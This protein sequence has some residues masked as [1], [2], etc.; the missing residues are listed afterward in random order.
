MKGKNELKSISLVGLL[1]AF[2]FAVMMLLAVL[3]L[4]PLVIL[5]IYAVFTV[6]NML[7]NVLLLKLGLVESTLLGNI[8]IVANTILSFILTI[9]A[10][11]YIVKLKYT[12]GSRKLIALNGCKEKVVKKEFDLAQ[13]PKRIMFEYSLKSPYKSLK[14]VLSGRPNDDVIE[15]IKS[16]YPEWE[17]NPSWQIGSGSFNFIKAINFMNRLDLK[18]LNEKVPL[19][20]E[21]IRLLIINLDN[22]EKYSV[23]LEPTRGLYYIRDPFYSLSKKDFPK[24]LDGTIYRIIVEYKGQKGY[25]LKVLVK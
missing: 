18:E 2:F 15:Y 14:Q 21:S 4:L 6:L 5:L 9:G 22:K 7:T 24:L 11:Y 1:K 8:V 12:F 23:A 10:I 16:K 25:S 20:K 3:I 19:F 17:Y 13:Y